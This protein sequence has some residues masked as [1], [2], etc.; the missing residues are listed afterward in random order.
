[1]ERAQRL[2][3]PV[4]DRFKGRLIF[5]LAGIAGFV[6][7]VGF[8]NLAHLFTSHM[9]G[10]SAAAGAYF[11]LGEWHTA[12]G[13]FFPIPI[14]VLGVIAGALLTE[15]AIARRERSVFWRTLCLEAAVLVVYLIAG[16][17]QLQI[18]AGTWPY[19]ALGALPSF[20][21]G[22]QN[23]TL[24][25]VGHSSVRTTY[26]TGMLTDCAEAI[27][28]YCLWQYERASSKQDVPHSIEPN[29]D[30]LGRALLFGGIWLVFVVGA[31]AGSFADSSWRLN[32]LVAPIAGLLF[33][34]LLDLLRPLY[35]P[36]V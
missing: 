31:I 25:R 29:P 20:A 4:S 19:Y 7:A 13:R 16:D 26:V 9:S 12:L 35:T 10:N 6:D 17:R 24:R 14:F 18:I 33:M 27:T 15:L 3:G 30:S 36:S 21:M 34:A 5:L 22:L 11:G 32:A 1:M 8:L 2:A 28:G 23:A